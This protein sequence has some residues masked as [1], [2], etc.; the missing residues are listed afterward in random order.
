MLFHIRQNVIFTRNPAILLHILRII[1]SFVVIT[2]Y[3][4]YFVFAHEGT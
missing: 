4:I 1:G 3:L 2:I